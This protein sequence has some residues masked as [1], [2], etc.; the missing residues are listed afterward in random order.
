MKIPFAVTF[1]HA[2]IVIAAIYIQPAPLKTTP[3]RPVAVKTVV[4]PKE[5]SQIAQS[6]SLPIPEQV[7]EVEAAPESLPEVVLE[8]EPEVEPAPIAAEKPTQL[9]T[10]PTPTPHPTLP[11]RPTPKPDPTP[12]AVPP[13]KRLASDKKPDAKTTAPQKA[14]VQKATP[15]KPAA[16]PV[17]SNPKPDHDKLIS[18]VQKSLNTL[19]TSGGSTGATGK[20]KP[21][22]SSTSNTI[23]TLASETLSFEAKYEEEL[24]SYLQAL[25]SFPEKGD[26][27][28]KLTLKREGNV[29]KIEILKASSSKNREYVESSLASCSFPS[30]GSHF[31]GEASH[32]FTLN[33][34]STLSSLK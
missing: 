18:M 14:T 15:K 26:V 27:K 9:P 31:K 6:A 32:T 22:A 33:L 19:N 5:Q 21:S 1:V 17:A 34:T 30:F 25:L 20:G 28:I 7:A 16:K 2:L 8:P 3:R 12:R 4:M 10:D 11:P 24:V 13:P 29:Q 23:G